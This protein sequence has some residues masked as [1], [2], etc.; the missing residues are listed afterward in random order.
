MDKRA[1]EKLSAASIIIQIRLRERTWQITA[2]K[3][4]SPHITSVLPATQDGGAEGDAVHCAFAAQAEARLAEGS[5]VFF[6][7][8]SLPHPRVLQCYQEPYELTL[9]A[10]KRRFLGGDEYGA[11]Q[12]HFVD[13]ARVGTSFLIERDGER[14]ALAGIWRAQRK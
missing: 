9:L 3:K 5:R 8:H 1:S 14:Q 11:L 7:L 10:W 2:R 13:R 6:F 4:N 12:D